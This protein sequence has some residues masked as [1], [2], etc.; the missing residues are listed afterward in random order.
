MKNLHFDNFE[1]VACDIADT[2]DSLK[3]E[4]FEDVTIIAK[5]DETRQIVKELL[6]LGYDIHSLEIHDELWESYDS[7]Y[8]ISL[9]EN[10]V[11]CE[12]MLRENGYIDEGAPVI[13]VLDNCS[14]KVIPHCKGKIVYEVAVGIDEDDECKCNDCKDSEDD[15]YTINGKPATKDEFDKYVSQFRH[16]E[17]PTTITVSTTYRVNVN[18]VDKE[19]YEKAL[20]EL[21]EK[22]LDNVK[23]MLLNYFDFVSEMNE[24]EKLLGW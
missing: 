5:Y 1:D 2:Y 16:D 18:E 4:D 6:C 13:Y 24:W 10:E 7:E 20:N 12:P 23:D 15:G 3:G 22:Y 19:T 21:D 11:W 8:V 17:K 14:S 9:Y